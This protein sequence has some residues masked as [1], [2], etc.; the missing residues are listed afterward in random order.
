MLALAWLVVVL[1]IGAVLLLLVLLQRG[2]AASV[3]SLLY[4]V[5]PATALEALL[6]FDE[7]LA[8]V[9]VAGVV[10]AAVGRRARR[11]ARLTAG[12]QVAHGGLPAGLSTLGRAHPRVPT[13]EPP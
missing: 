2:S 12:S 4:L 7:R 9:S 6:L 3:S 5:P 8:A 11:P 1:S 10:V 13:E